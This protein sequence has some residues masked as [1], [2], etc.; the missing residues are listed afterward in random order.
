MDRMACVNLPN[1]PIQ[2]LLQRHPDWREQPV[3]VVDFDKPQGTILCVNDCAHV[4]KVRPGMRYAAGLS[5]AGDLRASVVSGKEIDRMVGLVN[6]CLGSHSPRVEPASG[7]PGVFWLD[8]SGI[9]RLYGTLEEWVHRIRTDLEHIRFSATIVLG[10]RRFA[11]YALTKA[12]RG[13]VIIKSPLEEQTAALAV[14]LDCLALETKTRDLLLKL[15]IKT[16]GRFVQLPPTG[17]AKRFGPQVEQLHKMARSKLDLPL[18]P[19]RYKKPLSGQ[20]VLDYPE[21]DVNRLA[22][23]VQQL[24]DPILQTLAKQGRLVSELK[25]RLQFSRI[26]SHT[27]TLRP[28]APTRDD[29]LLLD[30]VRLRLQ[31]VHRLPDGVVEI[32]LTARGVNAIARQNNILDVRPK[33]D[34]DAA[35]RALARVRAEHGEESVVCAQLRDAHLPEAQYAWQPLQTLEPAK[36]RSVHIGCSIR[37]IKFRPQ[38]LRG[39]AKLQKDSLAEMRPELNQVTVLRSFGPFMVSGGWWRQSVERAYFYAEM[40]SGEI[41]WIY[42]DRLRRRW[43]QQGRVE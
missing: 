23:T 6:E 38:L 2:L 36:P 19:I 16:V 20:K 26:D 39:W 21:T 22:L 42:Y 14:H 37:R 30:L 34:L 5:L 7:E 9:K 24:L 40:Q 3:A 18:T 8:A 17:I 25:I 11:T 28:A 32:E 33:R 35:N 27:E 12:R 15:G 13:M 29:R 31:T 10:F 4:L 1:L 41:I 43:F